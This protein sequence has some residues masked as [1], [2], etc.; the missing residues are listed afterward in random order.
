MNHVCPLENG[1]VLPSVRPPRGQSPHLPLTWANCQPCYGPS[2]TLSLPEDTSSAEAKSQNANLQ[3][4]SQTPALPP[5][6]SFL[7]TPTQPTCRLPLLS[8]SRPPL[9]RKLDP[10]LLEDG[11]SFSRKL[12]QPQ[13]FFLFLKQP[14][15]FQPQGLFSSCSLHLEL[16][17]SRWK[18]L[19]Q[20]IGFGSSAP[21]QFTSITSPYFIFVLALVTTF[22]T[23]WLVVCLIHS[24]PQGRKPC[25]LNKWTQRIPWWSRD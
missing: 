7:H 16:F 5:P 2:S 15:L 25:L 3:I 9:S 11:P 22:K 21:S 18:L 12:H 14:K 8:P 6:S 23:L 19:L 20:Y 4:Q 1:S 10:P 13:V 24:A 17:S